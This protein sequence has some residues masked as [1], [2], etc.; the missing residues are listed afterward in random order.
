MPSPAIAR[1]IRPGGE[2]DVQLALA[3]A[4]SHLGYEHQRAHRLSKPDGYETF[5]GASA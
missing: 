1:R 2:I 4:R 3:V 5:L